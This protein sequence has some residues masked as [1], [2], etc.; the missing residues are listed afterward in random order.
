MIHK[1]VWTEGLFITQHHFQQ[2]D[3]YHEALLGER[4]RAALAWEW[5]V[6]H[7]E[8]DERALSSNQL[9]VSHL[10]AVLPDGTALDCHEG[11]P[12]AIP[13]RSFASEFSPQLQ[14]LDVSVAL[15]H[16]ML[17][18]TNVD[19]DGSSIHVARY[20]R[21]QEYVVDANTGTG[22]Q[23]VDRAHPLIRLLFGDEV[24]GSFD[25]IRIGQL[26]RGPTGSVQLRPSCVPPCLRVSASPWLLQGFRR[27]L[28]IMT[29]RQRSFAQARRQRTAGSIEVDASDTLRFLFLDVLNTNIPIFSHIVDWGTVHPEQAYLVISGLVGR[30]CS[31]TDVDPTTIPKFDYLDLGATFAPLFDMGSRMLESI[32]SER[33]TE[34]ELH[35]REDGVFV[36]RATGEQIMSSDYFL[37]V[38]G[39]LPEA[40]VRERLPK[41]MKIAS[42][43]QIQAILKSAVNGAQL[44]LEYRPPSALPLKPGTTFFRLQRTPDFWPDIASTGTFA[45]FH[46]FDPQVLTLKLYAIESDRTP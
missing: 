33:Y 20:A 38:S 13:P 11:K 28:T 46:P 18:A 39:T 25:A 22:E 36:G 37:A 31:F 7:L 12:D 4:L 44:E 21:K 29:A 43:N 1:L 24:K 34:I 14:S 35:R 32:I 30:L 27:L 6:T 9:L 8:I 5:G 10:S 3:R 45:L 40:Q 16:E 42:V 41:M 26:V 15:V 19:L 23:P 2:L 17:G